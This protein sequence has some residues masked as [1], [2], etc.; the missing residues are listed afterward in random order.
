MMP[1]NQTSPKFLPSGG[2]K[3]AQESG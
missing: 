3:M 2:D 1:G